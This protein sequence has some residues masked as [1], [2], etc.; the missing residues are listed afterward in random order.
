M[1]ISLSFKAIGIKLSQKS[2]ILF[3][4]SKVGMI[5]IGLLYHVAFI[6]MFG[7]I[8]EKLYLRCF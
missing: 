2:L 6:G 4:G 8:I 7:K 5:R 1:P 3:A